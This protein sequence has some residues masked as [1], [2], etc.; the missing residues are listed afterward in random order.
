MKGPDHELEACRG[1]LS[2]ALCRL[3]RRRFEGNAK[4]EIVEPPWQIVASVTAGDG[5]LAAVAVRCREFV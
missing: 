2:C 1:L 3:C 4:G 5:M